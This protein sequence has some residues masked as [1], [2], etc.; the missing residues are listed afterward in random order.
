MFLTLA[1]GFGVAFGIA[2]PPFD[3]PDEWRHFSRAYVISEGHYQAAGRLPPSQLSVPVDVLAIHELHGPLRRSHVFLEGFSW[4]RD[5]VLPRSRIPLVGDASLR[6]AGLSSPITYAPQAGFL[7]LGRQLGLSAA[8]LLYLGRL[9]TLLSWASLCWLAIRVTP[10]RRWSFTLLCLT[11][12]SLFL[13]ASVSADPLT[14][15]LSLLL[16]ALAPIRRI[17]VKAG[18]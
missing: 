1:L 10:T 2:T 5:P 9:A 8:A 13:A 14:S 12:M 17:E 3:S 7:L 18:H 4:L 16:L 11:P 6:G 15:G